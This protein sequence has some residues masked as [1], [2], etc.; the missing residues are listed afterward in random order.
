MKQINLG[1]I[2]IGGQGRIHLRNCLRLKEAKLIGVADISETALKFAKKLGIRN[3]YK[4]YEDLLSN[5]QIDAV[6]ISLPN[7][8]HLESVTKAAEAGKDIFLEK[9]LAR[10]VA[11]GQ[12]ILSSVKRNG[13]KL[14]LGYNLRFTAI[15]RELY[16]KIVDGFFGEVEIV[17]ATNVSHGPF[18]PKGGMK[19]LRSVPS[20]WFNKEL[21]GGG[22][23][24]DL[25]SHLINLLIWCFGEIVNVKS[26]LGYKFNLELED[27]AVCMLKFKSGPVATVNVGWFSKDFI[28]NIQVC[29]TA[30]SLCIHLSP[31][32]ILS[33]V[34]ADIKRKLG[35]FEHDSYYTEL[36]Y[37]VECL[38]K[39]I[40]PLPSGKEGLTDLQVISMA[41]ENCII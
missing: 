28:Q 26:Y 19:R 13:V 17:Q 25:G 9:P 23:L 38:R 22:A 4:N 18:T 21:A 29:G 2:G 3:V 39:D 27:S 33:L 36:K 1:L 37:F 41:Y 35:K 32:S 15:I 20:W 24:L 11:E 7:F 8:L 34:W 6:I 30:K 5:Q 14:M 12:K 40:V 16:E 10:N 31:P